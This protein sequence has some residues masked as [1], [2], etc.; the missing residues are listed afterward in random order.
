MNRSC[1]FMTMAPGILGA[2]FAFAAATAL[3]DPPSARVDPCTLVTKAEAEAVLGVAIVAPSASDD[4]LFRH[5][6]YAS[7]DKR[8][9]LYFDARDGDQGNFQSAM[10]VN[11]HGLPVDPSM[12]ADAYTDKSSGTLLLWK[13]GVGLNIL[14]GD[15]S[16]NQ[17]AA[18]LLEAQ[19]KIAKIALSRL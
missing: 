5:C 3:A 8:H 15:Q 9:Y 6:V 11:R 17:S 18:K 12:G 2:F 13:K 14:I 19:E 16:G 4:G 7:A 1:Q 10:K